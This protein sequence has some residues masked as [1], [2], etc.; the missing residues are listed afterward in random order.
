MIGLLGLRWMAMAELSWLTGYLDQSALD[1]ADEES[2]HRLIFEALRVERTAHNSEAMSFVAEALQLLLFDYLEASRTS[3]QARELSKQLFDISRNLLPEDAYAVDRIEVLRVA[4]F[5]WLADQGPVASKLLFPL[6]LPSED[7]PGASWRDRVYR[8][9]IDA[10]LLLLRKRDWTDIDLLMG[11]IALLREEQSEFEREYLTDR[12]DFAH[13]A[14]WELVALYHLARAAEIVATYISSGSS[15]GRFDPR[16]QVETHF[17]RALAATDAAKLHEVDDVVR[18]LSFLASQLLDNSLWSVGRAAGPYINRFIKSLTERGRGKPIFE[19]L[20]PQRRALADG[21]LSRAGQRSVVVSLPT[22]SGKTLIAQFRILQA[23]SLFA[24][25]GGWVAYVAPTRALANQVANRLRRDFEPLGLAVERVSAA[26]E[27]DSLEADI[28]LE[29]NPETRFD[30]LVTTPEKLDLMLRGGWQEKIGRPLCLLVVDE[31]HNIATSKRGLSLELLLATVNRES[32]DSQFLLLTPFID[33]AQRVA[34]WLDPQSGQAVDFRIDW[35]PNDR[36]IFI[37]NRVRGERRGDFSLSL[38]SVATSRR[39]LHVPE[40]ITIDA[41]RPLGLSWSDAAG[42]NMLAAATSD[43]LAE[44]G[45]TITL[46]QRPS[47]AWSIATKLLDARDRS[48]SADPNVQLVQRV[49]RNEYGDSFPLGEMLAKGIGLHHSGLSDEIRIITEWMV[50][51]SLLQHLVATT[52]VA[53]GVNFPVANVVFATHQFPYGETMPPADFWNIV[54]RAGRVDQ[55]E[56]GVI[57]LVAPTDQRAD[58]LRQFVGTNLEELGST[59]VAMVAEAIERFGQL[60]LA[61]LSY[62]REWSSFVQFIAHTYRQIGTHEEFVAEVEQVLRGT[63][64]FQELRARTPENANRLVQSVRRYSERLAGK[65]LSLV[66]STGFSWESVEGTFAR[67]RDAN[68]TTN[69]WDSDLFG[70]DSNRLERMIGVMLMVP[71][72]REN[73]REDPTQVA[74]GEGGYIASVVRDWVNGASLPELANEYFAT[75][76]GDPVDAITRC[77]RRL[78]GDIAPTVAWGLSALQALSLGEN[79]ENLP[80]DE[81]R[82][83]RNLPSYAYYG[84]NTEDAVML[85]LLNVPRLAA[86]GLSRSLLQQRGPDEDSSARLALARGQLLASGEEVWRSALGTLGPDYYRV[87]QIIDGRA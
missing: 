62:R 75:P 59:L 27:V 28:L 4:C 11:Q 40:T 70:G 53:Q 21:G 29:Q 16:Q 20:P 31:A 63:L 84:V 74:V 33:N 78:F 25:V 18:L 14:A 41:N 49:V 73:L 56:V 72:L 48:E 24:S 5:G 17:D 71:E 86:S 83:L 87:W 43:V 67:L 79:V 47:Y 82:E 57:A 26:L 8:R 19:V 10:W 15:E 6:N 50:E 51:N 45:L 23:L 9:L 38:D 76:T 22:S 44:R 54:G 36:V 66:D 58:E 85:R 80:A 30:V 3:E 35:Q 55:D 64:G 42:P 32:R 81:Q 52:T 1:R 69:S 34:D 46:A 37:G 61:S 2:A 68:I 65:P 12:G 13:P 7:A 60:D 77:C 39:T